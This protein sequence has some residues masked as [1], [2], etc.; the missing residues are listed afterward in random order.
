MHLLA[1][2]SRSIDQALDLAP[3]LE[4]GCPELVLEDQTRRIYRPK[5]SR[6]SGSCAILSA[7]MSGPWGELLQSAPARTVM[8]WLEPVGPASPWHVWMACASHC[9]YS[10]RM[11]LLVLTLVVS[12][13]CHYGDGPRHPPPPIRPRI[14]NPHT[15]YIKAH[16]AL[17]LC[18]LSILCCAYFSSQDSLVWQS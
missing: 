11:G 10:R 16:I 5:L 13:A 3:D 1:L 8:I 15:P 9:L 6:S 14:N 17:T 18:N 7:T 4:A 12:K 2:I